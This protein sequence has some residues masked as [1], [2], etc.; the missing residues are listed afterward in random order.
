[1]SENTNDNAS[2]QA[3]SETDKLSAKKIGNLRMVWDRAICYPKQIA[4]AA[5][6]LFVAAMATLAIPWGFKSIVDEGFSAEG[7]DVAPYFQTLL[8]IVAVLAQPYQWLCAIWSSGLAELR[9]CSR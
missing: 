8:V 5:I 7:G 2:E 3:P 1:M 6:A 4:F 9:S